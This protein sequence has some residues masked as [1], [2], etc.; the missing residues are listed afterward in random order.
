MA[1]SQDRLIS[2][3]TAA[4]LELPDRRRGRALGRLPSSTT[5]REPRAATPG[6]RGA[7]A[8]DAGRLQRVP[9]PGQRSVAPARPRRSTYLRR[10]AAVLGVGALLVAGGIVGTGPSGVAVAS[11]PGAPSSVVVRQGTTLWSL[12]DRYAPPGA[13][14]RAY[15][16][17][18]AEVNGLR[19]APQVGQ[20][21]RLPR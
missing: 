6:R 16:D 13:D 18:L 5:P 14:P 7:P 1:I 19:G 21:L 10:R 3:G 2:G 9:A 20:R 17:A 8:L 12:A 4:V 11:R 15:V